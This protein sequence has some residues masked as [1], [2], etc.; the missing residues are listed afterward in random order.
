MRGDLEQQANFG[1][2][3]TTT[4]NPFLADNLLSSNS[5]DLQSQLKITNKVKKSL[6]SDLVQLKKSLYETKQQYRSELEGLT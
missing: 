4:T 1:G 2:Q 6:E 5:L 3:S